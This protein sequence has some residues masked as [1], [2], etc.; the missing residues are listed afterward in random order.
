MFQLQAFFLTLLPLSPDREVDAQNLIADA[1]DSLEESG[2]DA[3]NPE[4][5]AVV[6]QWLKEYLRSAFVSLHAWFTLKWSLDIAPGS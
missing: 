2:E 6:A 4:V 3:Y 1:R 5:A